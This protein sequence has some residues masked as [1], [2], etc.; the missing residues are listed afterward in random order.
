MYRGGEEVRLSK[1]KGDIV[2]LEDLVDEVEQRTALVAGQVDANMASVGEVMPDPS[3]S[4]QRSYS[5]SATARS[6]ARS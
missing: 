6:S 1:R 3:G 5:S 4:A 2:S